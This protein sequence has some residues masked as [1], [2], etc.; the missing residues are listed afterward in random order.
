MFDDEN[1]TF[2]DWET[3]P[4]H[5]GS[6]TV[7]DLR[8]HALQLF[9]NYLA[10]RLKCKPPTPTPELLEDRRRF[11]SLP[12]TAAI[13]RDHSL[14][15]GAPDGVYAVGGKGQRGFRKNM[16]KLLNALMSRIMSNL[17]HEAVNRGLVDC[18]FD[19]E[20]NQFAFSVSPQGEALVEELRAKL[21]MIK[22]KNKAADDSS[23]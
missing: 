4:G 6:M 1:S 18:A 2:H 8:D 14:D 23:D 10:H 19:P 12:E 15:V 9:D 5:M 7:D 3:Q 11:L 20:E 21:K 13:L 22:K 17:T 16:I